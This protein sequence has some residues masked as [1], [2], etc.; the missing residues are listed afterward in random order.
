[1]AFRTP[2]PVSML[3]C[4][5]WSCPVIC[6]HHPVQSAPVKAAPGQAAP[7][8]PIWR[9]EAAMSSA[10]AARSAAS[11]PSPTA[12]RSSTASAR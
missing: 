10:R 12:S 9:T 1:M 11:A 2:D 5:A 4:T 7:M 6:P 8:A 3:P